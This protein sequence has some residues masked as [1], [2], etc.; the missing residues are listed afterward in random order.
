MS[1][2]GLA[3]FYVMASGKSV[4]KLAKLA[5]PFI[6]NGYD[7]A[8]V[9]QRSCK[10]VAKV[11]QRCCRWVVYGLTFQISEKWFFNKKRKFK[12]TANVCRFL[13]AFICKGF[14]FCGR[15]AWSLIGGGSFASCVLFGL[16]LRLIKNKNALTRS[17]VRAGETMQQG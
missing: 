1:V 14:R 3:L 2:K 7:V 17:M 12:N 9:L 13:H 11:L 8:K 15:S 6:Y 4:A 5:K 16:K 10:G